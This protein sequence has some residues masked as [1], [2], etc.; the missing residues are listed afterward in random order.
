MWAYVTPNRTLDG[1][2]WTSSTVASFMCAS[3][4]AHSGQ[5]TLLKYAHNR[6]HEAPDSN[7]RRP[8]YARYRADRFD[9]HFVGSCQYSRTVRRS[10][11][12][13]SS[14]AALGT[15]GLR[16]TVGRTRYT[17]WRLHELDKA[18]RERTRSTSTCCH[19]L[20]PLK[21]TTTRRVTRQRGSSRQE[22]RWRT[23]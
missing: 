6:S 8:C 16:C 3:N 12:R 17:Q 7:G 14:I 20:T 11:A 1:R 18:I 5:S 22:R 21:S 15:E 2:L 10:F 19:P 4:N 23:E 9:T 13:F